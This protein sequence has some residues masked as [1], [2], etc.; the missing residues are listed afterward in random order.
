MSNSPIILTI[1]TNNIIFIIKKIIITFKHN[2]YLS[3]LFPNS[4]ITVILSTNFTER[5]EISLLTK[6]DKT[7]IALEYSVDLVVELP[8][9]LE[10]GVLET[11]DEL[12]RRGSDIVVLTNWYTESQRKR[13]AKEEG[14]MC[15]ISS[16]TNVAAALKLAKK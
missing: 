7:R 9:T 13:L 10:E 15:G 5:G 11:L 1:I 12:K 3:I 2:Y 16:G 14:L 6:W 8:N 4:F